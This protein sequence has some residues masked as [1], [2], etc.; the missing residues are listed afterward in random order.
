MHTL[1]L[2]AIPEPNG[3]LETSWA[4]DGES[5]RLRPIRG[6]AYDS[7]RPIFSSTSSWLLGRNL[8]EVTDD[9][10]DLLAKMDGQRTWEDILNMFALET[11]SDRATVR[12]QLEPL[13]AALSE[14]GLFLEKRRSDNPSIALAS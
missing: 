3:A 5:H 12:D 13:L 14:R 7:E 4:I 6:V 2:D 11:G 8:H 9:E 1:A 10:A